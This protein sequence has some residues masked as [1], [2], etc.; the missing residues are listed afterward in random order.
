MLTTLQELDYHNLTTAISDT[1]ADSKS[2]LHR[3]IEKIMERD[4]FI[5]GKIDLEDITLKGKNSEETLILPKTSV[6]LYLQALYSLEDIIEKYE[7]L[8]DTLYL[9]IKRDL[10]KDRINLIQ[11]I[12]GDLVVSYIFCRIYKVMI[13]KGRSVYIDNLVDLLG[14]PRPTCNYCNIDYLNYCMELTNSDRYYYQRIK[15]GNLYEYKIINFRYNILENIFY[16]VLVPI[17]LLAKFTKLAFYVSN[18]QLK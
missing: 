6:L 15:R 11:R 14:L 2:P 7:I 4:T 12:P 17:K 1:I 3:E 5:I 10:H 9:E 16:L 8:G 18:K 13:N